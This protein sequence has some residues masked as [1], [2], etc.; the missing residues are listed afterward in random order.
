MAWLAVNKDGTE[1][2]SEEKPYRAFVEPP[3]GII[4]YNPNNFQDGNLYPDG[5]SRY[6]WGAISSEK[7]EEW[8]AT[9]RYTNEDGEN[10]IDVIHFQIPKGSIKK[11]IGKELTWEDEPFE[12][13]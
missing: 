11:L 13:K 12:L 8:V 9:Y 2:I 7:A 3:L 4:Y 5:N 10:E 1:I 6:T